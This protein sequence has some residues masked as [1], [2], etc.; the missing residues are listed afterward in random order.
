MK[1]GI[2]LHDY[3]RSTNF[4]N[5][6]YLI[7]V[8]KGAYQAFKQGIKL[9]VAIGDFDSIS[10]DEYEELIRNVSVKKLNPVKDLTDTADA[11]EYAMKMSDDIT[12]LG[13]IEGN[14]IEHLIANL[15]LFNK[16]NSLK[17][18]N[19]YSKIYLLD[20][21]CKIFDN[22][23]KF[24]SFYWYEGDP[25]IDLN[26]FKYELNNYLLKPYDSLCISNEINGNANI[27]VKNGKIL[28]IE[29]KNDKI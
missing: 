5:Y 26:G 7:G 23:Y 6:D 20:K 12:I 14:R 28:V 9:N 17:I 3:D 15:N 29:T 24:I 27:F 21:S 8:D 2:I 22:E 19:K 18:I 10:N 25:I 13:G 1:I 16:C 4:N 11:L